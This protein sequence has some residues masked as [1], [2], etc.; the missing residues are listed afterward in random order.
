MNPC[1]MQLM[2]LRIANTRQRPIPQ[3]D[4]TDNRTHRAR[5]IQPGIR[6]PAERVSILASRAKLRCI[7]GNEDMIMRYLP[8]I[9]L[10]VTPSPDTKITG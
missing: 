6:R 8:C 1:Y 7:P 2:L 4:T 3:N 5:S 10:A 9:Y